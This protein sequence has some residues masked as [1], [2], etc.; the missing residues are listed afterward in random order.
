M[1]GDHYVAQQIEV[2]PRNASNKQ[3]TDCATFMPEGQA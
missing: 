3:E 2:Q 1:P